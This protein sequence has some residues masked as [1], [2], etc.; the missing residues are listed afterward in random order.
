MQQ[1]TASVRASSPPM[2][3]ARSVPTDAEL[4]SAH[5]GVQGRFIA[6]YLGKALRG[7]GKDLYEPGRARGWKVEDTFEMLSFTFLANQILPSEWM[8][9][10][11][12]GDT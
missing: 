12:A 8:I 5:I 2:K 10:F 3:R 6:Q 7:R 11:P 4:A 9:L 1:K